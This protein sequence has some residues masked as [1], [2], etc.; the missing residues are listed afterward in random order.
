MED[1]NQELIVVTDEE[2]NETNLKVLDYFFY[3]GDE[4]AVLTVDDED[5][6]CDACDACG[7]ADGD[8]DDDEA[9]CDCCDDEDCDCCDD[10]DEVF[11]MKVV[12]LEGDEIELQPVSDELAEQLM[13]VLESQYDDDEDEEGEGDGE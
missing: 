10:G 9:A 3:N 12:P 11:F 13:N 7:E 8:A 5:D 4:Y 2:G 6:A 1:N